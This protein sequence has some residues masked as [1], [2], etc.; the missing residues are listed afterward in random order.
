M[1]L[2]S[3][4]RPVVAKSAFVVDGVAAQGGLAAGSRSHLPDSKP[5]IQ[6]TQQEVLRAQ[7]VE[8]RQ[9]RHQQE[10][11]QCET[12]KRG[13]QQLMQAA[14]QAA[15]ALEAAQADHG[16]SAPGA[17]RTGEKLR[18]M[19]ATSAVLV[20]AA[21]CKNASCP[22]PHC[23]KMKKSHEH[24]VKCSTVGCMVC[25]KLK[26][27]QALH[28]K[29]CIATPG[30]SC[31]VSWCS[32][33]KRELTERRQQLS[34][35]QS[36]VC[37]SSMPMT[38]A[39]GQS[40]VIDLTGDED[41]PPPPPPPERQRPSA[42]PGTSD[43]PA[44]PA[45]AS[46][47]KEDRL[48]ARYLLVIA[49]AMRCHGCEQA[50]C[51]RSKDLFANHTRFCTDGDSCTYPRC[52]L[53]KNLMLHHRQCRDQA[54]AV[55]SPLRRW[56]AASKTS[57][58]ALSPQTPQQVL[59]P[60]KTKQGEVDPAST[61]EESSNNGKEGPASAPEVS[62]EGEDKGEPSVRRGGRTR[63]RP[64]TYGTTPW[65]E[66][67]SL[68]SLLAMRE[69]AD[70]AGRELLVR[71]RGHSL[72][73]DSWEPGEHCSRGV[74]RACLHPQPPN[75]NPPLEPCP[76]NR[77]TLT[78]SQMSTRG[79]SEPLSQPIRTIPRCRDRQCQVLRPAAT[80]FRQQQMR[81]CLPHSRARLARSGVWIKRGRPPVAPTFIL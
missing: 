29:H 50:E 68:C 17:D 66:G 79:W 41:I 23:E 26:P 52:A 43:P 53:S 36:A 62:K 55:C 12:A 75:L 39:A 37:G 74:C 21:T 16:D 4:A 6:A 22:V 45:S 30:E 14:Q 56:V 25:L 59:R 57:A 8:Q 2:P 24:L 35:R 71:W 5:S 1:Q 20:H 28:C 31:V 58:D 70:S 76:D 54:C 81:Q 65:Y 51:K 42:Q 7:R 69:R 32:R 64:D 9:R 61:S 73:E 47:T 11:A 44:T 13:S 3:T 40:P 18:L 27:L 48:L 34:G 38:S 77:L 33:A 49:H 10:L 15:Q 19:L 72:E 46:R 63:I 78:Q 60:I 67:P 80:C